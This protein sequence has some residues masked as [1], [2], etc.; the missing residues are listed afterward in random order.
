MTFGGRVFVNV[1]SLKSGLE[2][3][4]ILVANATMFS[5][6]LPGFLCGSKHLLSTAINS[7]YCCG[8]WCL[9]PERWAVRSL[10]SFVDVRRQ[11]QRTAT[12]INHTF[13]YLHLHD[14]NLI[15]K[16]TTTYPTGATRSTVPVHSRTPHS[17]APCWQ[18]VID[19]CPTGRQLSYWFTNN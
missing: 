6:L 14:Y 17:T 7:W 16:H 1:V 15:L 13:Y 11:R 2:M 10:H 3:C 19:F 9:R 12:T 8:W 4:G 5:H 18:W